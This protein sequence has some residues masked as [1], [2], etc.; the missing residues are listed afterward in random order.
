MG[1]D[2]QTLPKPIT[3]I[4]ETAQTTSAID[5]RSHSGQGTI[6][7]RIKRFVQIRPFPQNEHDAFLTSVPNWGL[8]LARFLG[9]G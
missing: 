2:P 3:C 9:C 1:E 8:P 4:E 5:R 6:T 7:E